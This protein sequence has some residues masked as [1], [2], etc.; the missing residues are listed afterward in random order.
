MNM[1]AI[2]PVTLKADTKAGMALYD[3]DKNKNYRIFVPCADRRVYL[4]D[5]R[6]QLIKRLEKWEDG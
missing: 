3:Y 6:G 1:L 5:I 2:S 4:Y